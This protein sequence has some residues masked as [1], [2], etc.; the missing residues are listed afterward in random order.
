MK[1]LGTILKI[2]GALA[3]IAAIIFV[4]IRYGEAIIAWLKRTLAKLGIPC[5]QEV[6]LYDTDEETEEVVVAEEKD[7]EN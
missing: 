7:F 4:I 5:C 2:I 6:T 1:T 3:A